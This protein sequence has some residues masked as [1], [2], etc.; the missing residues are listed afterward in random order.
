MKLRTN[1]LP[2]IQHEI[3]NL[4]VTSVRQ[5]RDICRRRECF[6]QDMRR[7]HG[8]SSSRTSSLLGRVSDLDNHTTIT[9]VWHLSEKEVSEVHLTCWNCSQSGHRYQD[10]LADNT[11][12]CYGCGAPSIYKPNCS[13]CNSGS[14]NY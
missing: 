10:C 14:K 2:E 7:K 12:F 5:L 6:F 11:I 3:L 4:T 13:K 1:F 9:P 8:T